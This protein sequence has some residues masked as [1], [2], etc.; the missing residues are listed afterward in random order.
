MIGDSGT[1]GVIFNAYSPGLVTINSITRSVRTVDAE[2]TITFDLT[3]AT[4]LEK[5]GY[6]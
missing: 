3:L 1:N 4:R 2:V 6:I 5:T